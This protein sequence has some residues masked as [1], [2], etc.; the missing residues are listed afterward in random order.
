MAHVPGFRIEPPIGQAFGQGRSDTAT[1]RAAFGGG[2]WASGGSSNGFLGTQHTLMTHGIVG[3]AAAALPG[4]NPDYNNFNLDFGGGPAPIGT[5]MVAADV[6][7]GAGGLPWT[8]YSPN[9]ASPVDGETLAMG[10]GHAAAMPA[11]PAGTPGSS[12]AGSTE[13]P[14][15]TIPT[16]V[17]Q[18]AGPIIGNL[19]LGRHA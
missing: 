9:V 7:T 14:A 10:P 18:R 5:P 19:Q 16:I 15:D 8:A 2:P 1:L 13:V 3:S 17:T 4:T 12:G 11:P 6:P